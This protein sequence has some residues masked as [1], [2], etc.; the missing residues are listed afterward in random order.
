[1]NFPIDLDVVHRFFSNP[2]LIAVTM[3]ILVAY[4][5]AAKAFRFL[6]AFP[7]GL[8]LLYLAMR[9]FRGFF[10]VFLPDVELKWLAVATA[11]VL[12]CA[13]VRLLFY[14]IIERWFLWKR[15]VPIPKITRDFVLIVTYAVIV[16][17]LMRT[18]GNVNLAGLITTSAVLTA[19][20][21]LAAQNT[22]GNLLSG[23]SIQTDRPFTA[24]DWIQYNEFIG[25]VIGIG[26]KTTRIMTFENEMIVIPNL[27]ITK[28]AI[29][30]F[31][32]PTNQHVMT[33]PIG[34]EYAASPNK[35]KKVLSDICKQDARILASPPPIVRLTGYGDFAVNY[36]LRFTYADYGNSLNLKAHT[37]EKIWYAF[38]R[39]KIRIPFPIRDVHHRHIERRFE[40][41]TF[42]AFRKEAMARLSEVPLFSPLTEDE[43]SLIERRMDI[44]AYGAGE[45]IVIQDDPGDSA[46]IIHSGSCDVILKGDGRE[47]TVVATLNPPAIFGEMSLLTGEPR[48][49]TVAAKEDTIVFAIKKEAFGDII[50]ANPP[51]S[52]ALAEILVRRETEL[53]TIEEGRRKGISSKSNMMNRIKKFFGVTA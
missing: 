24:G 40:E 51:V 42:D 27:D 9:L 35:V 11:A 1:M 16:L 32:R 28:T 25:Q 23:L 8:F 33:I 47:P 19:S 34:V 50:A 44:E 46:F 30:N 43:R 39:N 3:F 36:E 45:K 15:G 12:Y 38:R 17:V 31:S 49:A 26:W 5:V 10:H 2:W 20:I 53:A 48:S 21:G 18:K 29:K 41:R 6:P 52:E 14:L 22:L 13:L 7:L 37:I 4:R